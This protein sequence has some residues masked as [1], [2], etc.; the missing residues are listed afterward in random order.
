[1][2]RESKKNNTISRQFLWRGAVVLLSIG[3]LTGVSVHLVH[4]Y[5]IHDPKFV[6][7]HERR[8]ALAIEGLRYG[9]RAK[10]QHIFAED[11]DHSV[12]SV[13]L[14]ERRRRLLAIDWVEDAAVSRIWPD[15]LSVRIQER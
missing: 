9:S 12:F 2:A 4:R 3:I 7:S 10:V 14:D 11:A 6:L 1:M 5:L 15:R 13:P 8:D